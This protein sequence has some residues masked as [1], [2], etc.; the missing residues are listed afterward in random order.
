MAWGTECRN[1]GLRE[2]IDTQKV[3]E[4]TGI[5]KEYCVHLK[6]IQHSMS[7]I[8]NETGKKNAA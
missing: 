2:K 4:N 8:F 3:Q 7:I 6:L 5:K 1:M